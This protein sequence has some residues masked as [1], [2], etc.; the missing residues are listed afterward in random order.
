[1]RRILSKLDYAS[2]TGFWKGK[3]WQYGK[4][5]KTYLL[6][7]IPEAFLAASGAQT[8]LLQLLLELGNR[9]GHHISFSRHFPHFR[10]F[11]HDF[12]GRNW[13]RVAPNTHRCAMCCARDVT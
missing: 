13:V 3:L 2:S 12:L 7:P 1:M 10:S 6:K 9:H 11:F 8:T 5:S 4:N